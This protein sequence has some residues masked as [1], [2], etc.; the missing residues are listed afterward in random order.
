ML[1]VKKSKTLMVVTHYAE[2]YFNAGD[3]DGHF[4]VSGIAADE[5]FD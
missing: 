5:A 3:S 1:N 2:I 4:E